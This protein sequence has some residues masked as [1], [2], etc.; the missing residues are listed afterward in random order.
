MSDS[1]T[2]AFTSGT[3]DIWFCLKGWPVYWLF[4]EIQTSPSLLLGTNMY[5][6]NSNLWVAGKGSG[7]GTVG[8]SNSNRIQP[9]R[10]HNACVTWTTTGFTAYLDGVA[11]GSKTGTNTRTGVFGLR[12]LGAATFTLTGQSS[13]HNTMLST[14]KVYTVGLDASE[15]KQNYNALAEMHGR[16][17]IA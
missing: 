13:L 3:V 6:S 11:F 17:P 16:M 8:T 4:S 10:W 7:I 1:S 15:V 9:A 5:F 2:A 14:V 12:L